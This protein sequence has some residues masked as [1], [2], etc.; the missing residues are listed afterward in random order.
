MEQFQY[1]C[2]S[3]ILITCRHLNLKMPLQIKTNFKDIEL[4]KSVFIFP[5]NKIFG[6]HVFLEENT[7]SLIKQNT[8]HFV[9]QTLAVFLTIERVSFEACMKSYFGF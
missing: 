9:I 7:N 1:I 3:T 2:S 8:R 5:Q 6:S 4:Q